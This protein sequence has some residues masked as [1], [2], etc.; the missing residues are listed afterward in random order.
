MKSKKPLKPRKPPCAPM[1][2][3]GGPPIDNNYRLKYLYQPV[4]KKWELGVK[5]LKDQKTFVEWWEASGST[6]CEFCVRYAFAWHKD[7]KIKCLKCPLTRD[8]NGGC[9]S[10]WN[11]IKEIVEEEPVKR[12]YKYHDCLLRASTTKDGKEIMRKRKGEISDVYWNEVKT[13]VNKM[14]GMIKMI[15]YKDLK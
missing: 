9:C 11:R 13:L 6:Y 12:K 8:Y 15:D 10:G 14:Y 3:L 2:C 5:K 4:V 1:G 7:H